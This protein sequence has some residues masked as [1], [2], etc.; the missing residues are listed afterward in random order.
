MSGT[1]TKAPPTTAAPI[2]GAPQ[3][4][5]VAAA[6]PAHAIRI[7]GTSYPVVLPKLRDPRL[8]IAAVVISLHVLGQVGLNFQISVPQI[9]AAVGTTFV[10]G[11]IITFR[12]TRS[13]VWPA[14]AML[15]GNGIA[16]ILRVPDTP[17]HD[18]W[19]FHKWYVFV[20]V[21]AVSILIKHVV[22]YRGNPL[23]N[24]SNVALVIAFLVLGSSRAVPLDFWWAPMNGWMIAAY[25]VIIVGG[26][27]VVVRM[28][29]F[30][31]TV[32]FFAAFA[33][34]MAVIAAY[35]HSMT[36]N[37]AFGP[38]SGFD[39]WRA[40][41]SSPEVLIFAFF[42]IT[43]PKTVP[44][45]RVGRVVYSLLVTGACLLLIAPQTT[46]FGMKVGLLGGLT[47]MSVFRPLLDRFL[48]ETGSADDRMR[49][50][51]R[52]VL[53]GTPAG[54]GANGSA[55]TVRHYAKLGLASL[56]VVAVG[57]GVL[58]LGRSAST[59]FGS[60]GAE[61]FDRVPHAINPA[62][63]PEITVEQGVLDW[64]HAISG[65]GAQE[66]VLTLAENLELE[67]QAM[68]RSDPSILEAVD[69]GDRLEAMQQQLTNATA[70][71]VTVVH[72]Y[73][74]DTVNIT[75]I[76]PF[77][78]QDGLSLGLQSQGTV[79]TQTYDAAGTL[80]SQDDA[81]FATTFVMRRATGARWLI[82]AELSPADGE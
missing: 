73:L 24:P 55:G 15:T 49:V 20:G 37:W 22:H 2:T 69:H 81:A 6:P 40:V 28:K 58:V 47:V 3:E 51:A 12:Q 9:L 11:V 14:S 34:G 26:T 27:S 25:A 7:R 46:E 77:G 80:L 59:T 66:V 44:T 52:R 61:V 42:M 68:L 31:M 50:F 70:S 16:L 48:P 13:F 64:N 4:A 33:A 78:R 82:V 71:G 32:I 62:T 43:D 36:A 17:L 60:E 18:H 10:L 8:T 53:V 72:R 1:L 75:L 63:F 56:V 30:T 65:E 54:A 45:G 57:T 76:V 39:L 29:L 79:T 5:P 35:G 21:A 19:T 67:T 38:V 41:A 74:I 23:F